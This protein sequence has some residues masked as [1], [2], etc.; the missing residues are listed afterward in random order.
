M[1]RYFYIL[2]FPIIFLLASC[3]VSSA[4]EVWYVSSDSYGSLVVVNEREKYLFIASV[5]INELSAYRGMLLKEGIQSDN[6]GALQSLYDLPFDHLVEG[7]KEDWRRIYQ[8]LSLSLHERIE[9]LYREDNDLSKVVLPDTLE[10]LTG[11][12]T[13]VKDIKRVYEQIRDDSYVL[14]LYNVSQFFDPLSDVSLNMRNIREW[15]VRALDEI[16]RN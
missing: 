11:N 10:S 8:D 14:R 5:E 13:T 7:D 4:D 2:L 9:V 16:K 15:R 6:L 3:Q 1:S 12:A